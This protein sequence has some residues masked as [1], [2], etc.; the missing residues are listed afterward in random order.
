ML[1]EIYEK[2][3]LEAIRPDRKEIFNWVAILA[4]LMC[5]VG[6]DRSKIPTPCPMILN[7]HMWSRFRKFL[8]HVMFAVP[9]PMVMIFLLSLSF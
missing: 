1:I 5:K 7:G 3:T 6:S 2:L 4:M 8:T 9:N